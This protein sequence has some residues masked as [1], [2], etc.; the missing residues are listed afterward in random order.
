MIN[1]DKVYGVYSWSV[2]GSLCLC[3]NLK[4]DVPIP[5]YTQQMFMGKFCQFWANVSIFQIFKY[6]GKN[7]VPVSDFVAWLANVSANNALKDI[8]G[9]DYVQWLQM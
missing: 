3:F 6:Q 9:A 4:K 7:Q 5:I 2:L 1:H 8:V